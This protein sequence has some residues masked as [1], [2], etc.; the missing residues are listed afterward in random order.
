MIE[1]MQP[2]HRTDDPTLHSLWILNELNNIDK[3]RLLLVLGSAYE[4]S[5]VNWF[6]L[7]RTDRVDMT[8]RIP[9]EPGAHLSSLGMSPARASK[10]G[11]NMQVEADL[12]LRIVFAEAEPARGEA[13]TEVLS[14]LKRFVE[15]VVLTLSSYLV[16]PK[17]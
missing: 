14:E 11:S 13:I 12:S 1:R 5:R 15:S 3:H 6:G 7:R 17:V 16:P 9:L 2:Y 10:I 4:A 8:E